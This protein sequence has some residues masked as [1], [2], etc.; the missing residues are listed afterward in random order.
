MRT[1]FALEHSCEPGLFSKKLDGL[2][3]LHED[4]FE[5]RIVQLPDVAAYEHF[6]ELL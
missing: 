1:A 3:G 4:L 6:K 2:H 5:F